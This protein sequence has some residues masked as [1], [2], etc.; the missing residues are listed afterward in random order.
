MSKLWSVTRFRNVQH[1]IHIRTHSDTFSPDKAFPG[2]KHVK[3]LTQYRQI[4]FAL[5]KVYWLVLFKIKK[6]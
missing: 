5:G 1:S 4:W 6:L 2:V 3:V